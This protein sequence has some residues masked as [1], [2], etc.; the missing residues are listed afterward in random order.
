MP[1][2]NDSGFLPDMLPACSPEAQ[3]CCVPAEW[4]DGA[5]LEWANRIGCPSECGWKIVREGNQKLFGRPERNPCDY[6]GRQKYVHI[7]L[8]V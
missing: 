5:V 3:V 8:E 7:M 1:K 6:D 4:D 2:G